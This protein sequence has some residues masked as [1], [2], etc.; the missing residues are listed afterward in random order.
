MPFN[1]K[2]YD[3][4]IHEFGLLGEQLR[5]R[6][7]REENVLFEMYEKSHQAVEVSIMA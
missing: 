5:E 6:V 4:F 7:E 3:G 1:E 2:S